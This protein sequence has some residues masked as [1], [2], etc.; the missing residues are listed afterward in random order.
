[1]LGNTPQGS[2]GIT[3]TPKDPMKK[4]MEEYNNKPTMNALH[5]H[6]PFIA[7]P[8]ARYDSSLR[9]TVDR[10]PNIIIQSLPISP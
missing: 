6:Y 10:F 8:S 3:Q 2:L 1:M 9:G 4:V 7:S 5:L